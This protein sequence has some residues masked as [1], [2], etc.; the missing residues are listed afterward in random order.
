[1]I[2]VA[3]VLIADDNPHI[4]RVLRKLFTNEEEDFD[5]CGEA[6]NGREAIAK[7]QELR[8]DL[9]VIDL[10]MP[11][12]NGL[13]AARA[14][15]CLMPNV[16]ILMFTEYAEAFV[17]KEARSAGISAV[18]PKSENGSTLVRTARS[19]FQHQAAA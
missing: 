15:K 19:L 8:P 18:L 13:D 1:M 3:R 5:V 10:S 7:A 4:R 2:M 17:E 14:L 12:M 9:I 16:P 6:E 11:V